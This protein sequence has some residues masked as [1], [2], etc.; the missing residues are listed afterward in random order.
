MN[1]EP[2][3]IAAPR[4]RFLYRL[5]AVL[6][7]PPN[8]GSDDSLLARGRIHPIPVRLMAVLRFPPN[9]GSS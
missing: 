7:F 6:R 9:G 2:S 4:N 8:S 1:R 3:Q 5:M